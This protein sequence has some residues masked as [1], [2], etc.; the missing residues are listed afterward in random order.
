[1]NDTI[2]ITFIIVFIIVIII[3]IINMSSSNHHHHII[4]GNFSSYR[5]KSYVPNASRQQL[6][7]ADDS[8]ANSS[9]SKKDQLKLT[10][11]DI[12]NDHDDYDD[13]DDDDDV[14]D[15]GTDNDAGVGRDIK[16]EEV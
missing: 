5:N 3:T 6:I 15:E 13:D 16:K 2:V 12:D 8:I 14:G 11:L 1:L 10:S 9:R 4:I 7:S